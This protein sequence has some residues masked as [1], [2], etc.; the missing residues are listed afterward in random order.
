[1]ATDPKAIAVAVAIRQSIERNSGPGTAINAHP[2]PFF[3]NVSGSVDLYKAAEA[4]LSRIAAYDEVEA[5]RAAAAARE[6]QRVVDETA[7][8]AKDGH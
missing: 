5:V 8:S 4:A 3:V 7:A 2:N 1:M 6:E